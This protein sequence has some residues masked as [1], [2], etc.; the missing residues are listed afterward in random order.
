[1]NRLAIRFAVI[2]AAVAW[3]AAMAGAALAAN[4]KDIAA[5]LDRAETQE[6]FASAAGRLSL[7]AEDGSDPDALVQLGR[8][9]YLLGEAE[10][11]KTR[12]M[13][14]LDKSIEASEKALKARPDNVH[15]LYW[16]SMAFLQKADLV[17]G[18]SALGLV[19]KA[20][21]GLEEVACKD[22]GYDR[23]GACRSHGK[24]LMEA[25]A[26]A[27]IG[28]KKRGVELLEKARAIAPDSLLNRLYLAEAYNETG[29]EAEALKEL[30][31]IIDAPLDQLRPGDDKKVKDDAQKLLKKLGG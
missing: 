7:I 18:L 30:K 4:A 28:D 24:V 14:Y 13:G 31:F 16:G 5:E 22:E 17:G 20:L 1:M 15:A 27:F 6:A 8:A 23:A 2:A 9:Y 21:K 12:R 10:C 29:R 26:W 25:P 19:K 11:D 3:L